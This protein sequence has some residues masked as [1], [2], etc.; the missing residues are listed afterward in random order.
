MT[1]EFCYHLSS[2]HHSRGS[3]QMDFKTLQLPSGFSSSAQAAYNIKGKCHGAHCHP[4][5]AITTANL[6][7]SSW[8]QDASVL[9]FLFPAITADC[10]NRGSWHRDASAVYFLFPATTADCYNRGSWHWDASALYFLFP[11]TTADCFNPDFWRF[12]RVCWCGAYYL[13]LRLTFGSKA[14]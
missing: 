13:A 8:H 7:G 6:C 5:P 12:F 14:A 3:A 2:S 4:V 10:F 1:L 9:C 11:T